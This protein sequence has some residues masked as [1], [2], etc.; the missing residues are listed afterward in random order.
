ME[1]SL[2]REH[3]AV[4]Y[5]QA[6]SSHSLASPKQSPTRKHGARRSKPILHNDIT[7]VARQKPEIYTINI[8][9][10]SF[11]QTAQNEHITEKKLRLIKFWNKFK[12]IFS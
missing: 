1:Q 11:I 8:N 7:T 2:T 5:S 4:T 3:G 10:F 9:K 6:Q 12:V